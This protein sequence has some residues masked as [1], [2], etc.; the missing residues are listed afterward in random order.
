MMFLG[1]TIH[2]RMALMLG[3]GLF[4][5]LTY[6]LIILKGW[7]DKTYGMPLAAL[8]AN[9]SW[10]FLFGFV[11]QGQPVQTTVNIVW[12][13]ADLAILYTVLKFGPRE[14]PKLRP[15]HFYLLVAGTLGLAFGGV[16]LVSDEFDAGKATYA[17]FGQ[18]LM[19]SALFIAMLISRAGLRGQSVWIAAAKLAGTALASAAIWTFDAGRDTPLLVYLY[20]ATLLLDLAYLVAVVLV[21]RNSAPNPVGQG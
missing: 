15:W 3:S 17:A 13:V 5:T 4:W 18:N 14:F 2:M 12:F 21:K 7:R 6:V 8:G 11:R 20:L 10:E 1:L 19:M 9:L 16:L